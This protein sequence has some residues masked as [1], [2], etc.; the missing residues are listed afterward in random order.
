M[1]AAD[2]VL[3][4]GR[5][6]ASLPRNAD[7][8]DGATVSQPIRT[9]WNRLQVRQKVWT[10]LLV[11]FLPLVGALVAHFALI[12]HLVSLQQ[13][14]HQTVLAS[15][16][17][18][19]L[20]RL[21]VD[22]ETAF[23]GY[24]LT[25]DDKFLPP[26]VEA[27]AK[28]G[29]TTRRILDL[30][31]GDEALT[32]DIRGAQGRL[33]ELL[34]SK[35]RLIERFR[36]GEVQPVL[37]YVR[38]GQGI[39]LADRARDELREIE[40]RLRAR[41]K[42]YEAEEARLARLA[43]W[44][45]VFAV[46]GGLALGLV[47]SR[48][49]TRSITGPLSLLKASVTAWGQGEAGVVPPAIQSSDEI[50]QLARSYGEMALRI[51]RQIQ[52]LETISAI[53][54]AINTIGPD[55]LDGVLRRIVDRAAELLEV[56]VCLVMSRSERMGC[57]IVE[58]ASGEWNDRLHKTVMLWEEFPV[59]VRAYETGEP[60]FGEDLRG[61]ARP[62][63]MRRNLMGESMLS[64]PL[65]AQGAPFG[66][67][68]LLRAGRIAR[69]RW[70]LRLAKGFAE[71][72]AIAIAN[73]RLYEAE[74]AKERGLE[75][76][77]R[78][79]EHLA[80]TLAHDLKA[81]GERME[82]L[83]S[84]LMSEYGA[85][86]DPKAGKWLA[87]L[88]HNG[89]DLIE[90]VENILT[91][92]RVG[93]RHEAVEA[94]DPAPL[95]DDVLKAWAGELERRRVRVEVSP[96]LPLVACHRAYLRQV[97][98]NLLSNA[99]KFCVGRPAPV[100]AIEAVRREDRVHFAVAD[101]GP[102]I[103]PEHRERV[104]QPFVRLQPSAKGSGIGLAIVKRIVELYGGRV[105]IDS[106]EGGGCVVR[107]TLPALGELPVADG[108]GRAEATTADRHTGPAAEGA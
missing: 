47:G 67:L 102:G 8:V 77:L 60:A 97:L 94:V 96:G 32:E 34:E 29:P 87:L 74:Q 104:F 30:V 83:A 39:L 18:N 13:Q 57:W 69:D 70:N 95:L 50:G 48:L 15:E 85:Q 82:E 72:A 41:A 68:V 33:T 78:Q 26:L 37:D 98:D 4:R 21:S 24:L 3:A 2:P 108:A 42:A 99:L 6:L 92:A 91:V 58:A 71:E 12:D 62:E 46:I 61:D 63:V 59:S 44:G 19:V 79:L 11:V 25:R 65:L 93:G 31:A 81:P 9:W 45:L 28:L 20:R 66:V 101:N 1:R 51:Q 53:G 88:A 54:H 16:Q 55:G 100:I 64:I 10:I 7:A 23:R 52:E 22:M 75:A 103:P 90:R 43:Y 17:V 36:R 40:D 5:G 105:W 73:A 107:F 14:H 49:L 56:D 27:E 89:R 84:L 76:R 38:S 35:H 86:L 106:A 80:E